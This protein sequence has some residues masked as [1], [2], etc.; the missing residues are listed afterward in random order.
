[1]IIGGGDAADIAEKY[2]SLCGCYYPIKGYVLNSLKVDMYDDYIQPD[3]IAPSS[4]YEFQLILSVNV[5]LLLKVLLSAGRVF[6][7]N[8]I[9]NK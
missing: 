4:E 6:L 3:F 5:A 7:K 9:K 8:L 1:M 2:G